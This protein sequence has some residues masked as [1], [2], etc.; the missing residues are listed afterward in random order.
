MPKYQLTDKQ[1]NILRV[2]SKG[3][4]CGTVKTEW[5]WYTMQSGTSGDELDLINGAGFPGAEELGVKLADLTIFVQLGFLHRAG[6][7]EYYHVNE[8]AIHD[9]VDNDFEMPDQ[10][11]PST[12]VQTNIHGNVI[13]SNINSAQYMENIS[14]KAGTSEFLPLDIQDYI[15][16]KVAELQQELK[17]FE[18]THRREIR[19]VNR[20]LEIVMEDLADSEPDMQNV[21]GALA[22]LKRAGEKLIFAPLAKELVREIAEKISSIIPG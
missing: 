11:V 3:L 15:Q 12:N 5:T 10:T 20:G 1:K 4:R 16:N 22:R 19:E 14:Q 17:D 7:R 18:E 2:A 8:Q 6:E 21:I 13:G 9:A